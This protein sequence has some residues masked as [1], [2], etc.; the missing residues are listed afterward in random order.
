MNVKHIAIIGATSAIAQACAREW[1]QRGD[2]LVLVARNAVRLEEIAQD[3]R[4]RATHE[5]IATFVMDATD[6]SRIPEFLAF[7]QA[8]GTSL[9]AALIA[10]GTLPDQA[11]CARSLE[12]TLRTAEV[13]GTSAVGWLAAFGQLFAEQRAGTLAVIGSPAGDRG[14]ASNYTYG[15]AKS[16]VHT[17]AEGLR[18]K[19][20]PLGVRVVLL[21]PGFVDTP[22]TQGFEKKGPL[23][24]SPS[25][26]ARGIV[27]A[28]DRGDGT[29]YVP[30]F[31]RYIMLIIRHLPWFV[32]RRMSI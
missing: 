7:V 4:V 26:V 11:E 28:V 13:N 21:K 9:D 29:V 10:Y 15:A 30:G 32:F 25:T 18:H 14:R 27:G 22:M 19:L 3:L 24:T 17:F 1:A 2:K 16:M 6:T 5:S 23:W 12:L 8:R 20:S 31:W